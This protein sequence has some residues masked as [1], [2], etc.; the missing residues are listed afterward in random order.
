MPFGLQPIHLIIIAIVALVIF[1]PSRLPELGRSL[2]K[3]ITEF[4][5]GM[6]EM[7]EGMKEE[8]N[9]P[10]QNPAGTPTQSV[11]TNPPYTPAQPMQ[12]YQAPVPSQPMQTYQTPVP[13]QPVQTVQTATPTQQMPSPQAYPLPQTSAGIT[14]G[15]CGTINT[16]GA[17]FC[18]Q[19]GAS[20]VN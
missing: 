2:G 1:G 19:C 6:R 15:H 10:D 18:N 14:C 5:K 20:L 17:R 11:P 16:P 4:R 8:L 7:T 13:T 9:T 3:A 12:T